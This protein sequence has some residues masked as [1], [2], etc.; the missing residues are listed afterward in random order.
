M[1][2]LATMN[3][4]DLGK[5]F[6]HSVLPKDTTESKIR[7]GCRE[8]V[9]YNCAAFYSSSP[10]W[11]PVVV[12]ELAGT[13]VH[14]AT[15]VAFPFGAA[16]AAVKAAETD[17][18]RRLGCTAIDLVMNIGALKS[19]R[20]QDVSAELRD[21]RSAA[22][23]ALTKVIL[24]TCFLDAEEI[25]LGCRLIAEAGIDYAKTSSGQFEG[26]SMDDFLL[27]RRTLEGT[28]VK[29]KVAGVKFP[30]PQNAYAFLLAGADLI[31]TRAVPEIIDALA[32]MRAIGLVPGSTDL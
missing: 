26:P 4:W 18:A 7:A 23:G 30:R 1:I 25:A 22:D 28:G 24:E 27:M 12:E 13:D 31:G 32:D 3:A 5:A 2:N 9:A 16:S 29:L 10:Y 21:F 15:A 20:T 11:T 19:G 14:V 17:E 8:A 6:D